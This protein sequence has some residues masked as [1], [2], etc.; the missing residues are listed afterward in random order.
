M[1]CKMGIGFIYGILG[2]AMIAGAEHVSLL[3][4]PETVAQVKAK[5]TSDSFKDEWSGYLAKADRLCDPKSEDYADIRS[6]IEAAAD[7]A[8]LLTRGHLLARQLIDWMQTLGMA[9]RLTGEPI[10]RDRAVMLLVDA[11]Q[12]MP[13][14]HAFMVQSFPG[15]RG[16]ITRGLATGYDLFADCLSAE[17]RNLI[18][19]TGRG[20]VDDYLTAAKNTPVWWRPYHNF[21]GVCGGAAGLM[22]LGLRDADPDAANAMLEQIVQLITD[23]LDKG[24][25]QEGSYYEGVLYSAYPLENVILFADVLKRTGGA[26][27]FANPAL[28]NVGDFYVL[29]A[30]PGEK[31]LDARNDS[32]YEN[33]GEIL[34]KLSSEYN[35][36]ILKW[37]YQPMTGRQKRTWVKGLGGHFFLKILWSNDIIPVSPGSTGKTPLAQHFRGRGLCIWRTGWSSN[38]VMFSIES[39][40]YYIVTHN[41]ADKGHFTFY[42]YGYRWACDP[43]YANTR[44][45][46]GRGQTIS[47]NCIL[48]DEAGQAISGAGTGT[49]G[50][51]L[52]YTNSSS[53]GY[54][55]ADYTESYRANYGFDPTN[56]AGRI[57]ALKSMNHAYRHTLFVRETESTP[58][59]AVI[60][61]DIDKDGKAHNYRWQM[62]SWPDLEIKYEAAGM[63]ILPKSNVNTSA[64]MFVFIDAEPM[65]I[66]TKDVCTPDDGPT[67]VVEPSSFPRLNATCAAINPYF[68]SVLIPTDG[69]NAPKVTFENTA[70]EKNIKIVWPGKTD[71]IVWKKTAGTAE[72]AVQFFSVKTN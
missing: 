41:Q 55:L 20:Y 42:G 62:L 11:A 15:I 35:S 72:N 24:F 58:A 37:L 68:A 7:D 31:V 70:E 8:A 39:G 66:I 51:I 18:L 64:R 50:K 26:D 32:L 36:G 3:M 21:A 28:K 38:D 13:V 54:A 10:Y 33:P 1:M 6:S 67:A 9:Y 49:F 65:P 19:T 40:P 25:D 5:I 29:S 30:L 53:F 14:D 2:L 46:K 57:G 61:D 48:I 4:P 47:H 45:P 52:S 17:Q 44:H 71:L 63:L 22:A 69:T 12:L 59:Y 27:L 23:W 34:L 43:G 60:L 16:D 56:S